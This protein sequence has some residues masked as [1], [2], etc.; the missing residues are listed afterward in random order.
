MSSPSIPVMKVSSRA[1]PANTKL[2]MPP[3]ILPSPLLLLT[4]LCKKG[5]IRLL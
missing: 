3:T 4:F 1:S 2:T 5:E